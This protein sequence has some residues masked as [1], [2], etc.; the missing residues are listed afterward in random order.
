MPTHQNLVNVAILASVEAGKAIMKIY[1]SNFKVEFKEDNSPLTI[2]DENANQIIVSYLE[3]TGIPIITE[4]NK[5]LPFS[6]RSSWSECW[7]VD[8]LDGTK[9][10]IKRNGEFTVNIAKV[11][12]GKPEFG[13][14]YVPVTKTL[15]VGLVEDKKSYKSEID[16]ENFNLSEILS[17]ENEIKP[18]VNNKTVRIVGSRSHLNE[19]TKNY[20]SNLS[21]IHKTEMISIGSSLK[22]CLV[23]EGKADIYPRFAP[24]MEWDTAA[25]QAI[26]EAVGINVLDVS[27]NNPMRYNKE[28]LLNNH[29]LVIKNEYLTT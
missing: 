6:E 9:E 7:I 24:T 11:N 3:K 2:A 23:A 26:C 27:T 21:K 5:Q 29:F 19:T 15:Y 8:P 20:I 4:E 14:I 12:N 25:G 16:I 18:S 28:N 17:L 22:F 1:E 13:V 10:F